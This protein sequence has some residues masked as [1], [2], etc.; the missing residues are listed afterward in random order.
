MYYDCQKIVIYLLILLGLY[1]TQ[2]GAKSRLLF[3][4]V[5]SL[6]GIGFALMPATKAEENYQINEIT[7]NNA[8]IENNIAISVQNDL[9]KEI[10]YSLSIKVFS[11]DLQE[12][13]ELESSNLVFSIEGLQ[14]YH[15]NFS[16]TIPRSGNY[17]FNLTLLSNNE[18]LITTSSIEH[19]YLF[20]DNNENN[21]EESIVDYYLDENDNANWLFNGETNQI[22]LINLE[23]NYNTGI[24]LGP[25]NTNGNKNN[26]LLINSLFEI[27]DTADYSIAYT[28]D[29]NQTQLYSTIWTDIYHLDSESPNEISL[30]IEDNSNIYL[31]L[32]ATDVTAT[33]TNFWNIGSITHKY[34]SIKHNL[35]VTSNEHYF[36]DIEQAAEILINVENTGIFDQQLGNITI[37]V[38]I[39][40]SNGKLE[41][42]LRTPNLISGEIQAIDFRFNNIEAGNYYCVVNIILVE[43]KIYS[44]EK[45]VFMSISTTYLQNEMLINSNH[46][47]INLLIE[48]EDIDD[49]EIEENY[50]A[51]NLIKDYYLIEID[52][53]NGVTLD[54]SN[55]RLISAISMDENRFEITPLEVSIET[56]EGIVA[57]S[58]V[59]NNYNAHSANIV[60][61]NEGFYSDEYEISYFFASTFIESLSGPNTVNVEPGNSENIELNLVPLPKVPREGGSQLQIKISN[62]YETKSI[63]YVLSYAKTKIE[64][65]EQKCN[66]HSVLLNQ[67]II[68]TNTI[69][70]QGYNS[71]QLSIDIIVS[72]ENGIIEVIDQINIEELKNDESLVIRT[73]YF[74]KVEENFKLYV[75]INSDGALLVSS[76]ME[77]NINVVAAGGEETTEITTFEAPEIKLTQTFFAISFAGIAL[78]FR[79]SE[80]FRY[81]TFKF[82]IP[83]YSR[84]QKDTLADEPTRQKLLSTIYTE[85]GTNFTQLKERLGLHNG[86]LAHHINILENNKMVTSH[87]SGRQRLFFPFGGSINSTIRNSLITNKTQKDIIQMVKENPGITQSMISQQLDMSRQKINYHVNSLSNNS[88]LRVEKQ[89]R[90][91]RLYPMHFT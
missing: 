2:M 58:I 52:N 33:E 69:S 20:Y 15:T 89:G 87:R 76:E 86:T 48:V 79:R 22:E 39:Y 78:Q 75:N 54:T 34:I 3:L 29:F 42:L 35:E 7:H 63:T 65:S 49:F 90:I 71:N 45:I 82:F 30:S 9:D 91:T 10:P 77:D 51:T 73:T 36:F 80:N 4:L 21:L 85:P 26:I 61:S 6:I 43:E 83:L 25:Y 70:N 13:I 32:L 37:S 38:D 47:R 55:Y 68:C 31:R 46:E 66:K 18:G 67:D 1:N 84:L 11:E 8:K 81:L 40:S 23:N 12:D 27:S 53:N 14:T 57:P 72:N 41:T 60:L 24:I 17:L 64:I 50:V 74:P 28:K 62:Q 19:E 88:I 44:I 59:F 16:F 5:A 56:I